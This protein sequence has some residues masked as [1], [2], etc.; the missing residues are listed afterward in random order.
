MN[1]KR[2][3]IAFGAMVAFFI[4]AVWSEQIPSAAP[5]AVL[6]CVCAGFASGFFFRRDYDKEVIEDKCIELAETANKLLAAE[7]EAKIYSDR[8]DDL[9][10][11]LEA[12]TTKK[13]KKAKEEP[14][15][16]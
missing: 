4:G 1:S 2:M 12:A 5:W 14:K 15:G 9:Q 13:S 16:E 11:R 6:F 10:G 8:I 7:T 3:L